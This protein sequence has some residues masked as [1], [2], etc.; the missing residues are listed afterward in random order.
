[1][2]DLKIALALLSQVYQKPGVAGVVGVA[3]KDINKLAATPWVS[4]GVAGVTGTG[5]S[6]NTSNQAVEG[7]AG[8]VA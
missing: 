1:M 6:R 8:K 7:V 2:R 3:D 5:C 4:E